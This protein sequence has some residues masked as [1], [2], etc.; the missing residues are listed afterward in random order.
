MASTKKKKDMQKISIR[1]DADVKEQIDAITAVGDPK[2]NR[3]QIFRD[4]IEL[5]LSIKFNQIFYPPAELCIFS[6]NL[7]KIAFDGMSLTDL[8]QM[9]NRAVLNS[10]KWKEMNLEQYQNA[11]IESHF[12]KKE[13]TIEQYMDALL[14]RVYSS[15]GFSWFDSIQ[16]KL[17]EEQII[18]KGSH[19]LGLH[20][21]IFIQHHLTQHL[22]KF[23]YEISRFS[24]T[25]V[26]EK[27][28]NIY[29]I[30]LKMTK[31]NE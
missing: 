9:A 10:E 27:D 1:L 5:W 4:A 18:M 7:L 29:N 11:W 30:E 26:E 14:D 3:S 6:K 2:M 13:D 28:A 17:E 22:R 12:I 20:F 16:Y 19:K 25:Y 21:N 23:E 15:T 31:S 24:S 8:E